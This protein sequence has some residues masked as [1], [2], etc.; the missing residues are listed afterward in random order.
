MSL[1]AVC[2]HSLHPSVLDSEL[3]PR[4]SLDHWLKELISEI[5]SSPYKL[6]SRI[7]TI[8]HTRAGQGEKKVHVASP[9]PSAQGWAPLGHLDWMDSALK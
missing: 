8:M 7:E 2:H 3:M 6:P 4:R 9:F 5:Y 1:I